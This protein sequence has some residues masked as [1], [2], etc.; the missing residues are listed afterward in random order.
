MADS[1]AAIQPPAGMINLALHSVI[2]AA[3]GLSRAETI[4]YEDDEESIAEH[5]RDAERFLVH[6]LGGVY[7]VL[8]SIG[9]TPEMS[10]LEEVV[11]AFK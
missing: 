11:E 3:L 4:D 5:L 9:E 6:A 2:A 1:P 7:A 8:H 10:R